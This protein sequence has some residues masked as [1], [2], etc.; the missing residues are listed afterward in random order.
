M[1]RYN[2]KGFT[3][4][5]MMTTIVIV[6][7]IASMAVPRFM[8]AYERMEFRSANKEITSSLRLARSLAISNKEIYGV[9]FDPQSLS[10]LIFKKDT[11]S[12]AFSTYE[13][14]DSLVRTDSFSNIFSTINTD[15]VGNTISFRPNGSAIYTG[16]GNIVSMTNTDEMVGI[17]QINIL[18][19]T[20]R[21]KSQ[22]YS[23]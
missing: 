4:I 11:A 7:I 18:A 14:A 2:R 15:F 5:E 12:T 20:G 19:S 21:I 9:N 8:I 13:V 22:S 17:A 16:G 23:Y 3:L 10:I 6:G 1:K